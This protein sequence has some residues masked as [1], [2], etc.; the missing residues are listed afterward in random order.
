MAKPHRAPRA[1][2]SY[3]HDSEAHKSWVLI[4]C[5]RLVR[6]GVDVILDQWDVRLGADLPAFMERGL[7]EAD[8]VLAICTTSYVTK[9]NA[10][11]GGVGYEKMILTAQLM[12]DL[13]SARVFPV[14]KDNLAAHPLPTFLASRAYIDFRVESEYESKYSLLLHEIHGEPIQPRPP[15]GPNPFREPPPPM[16]APVLP[17]NADRYVNPALRGVV[18]FDPTNNDGKF[19]IGTGDMAFE[20]CW[21]SLNP[22]AIFAYHDPPSIRT[23][24]IAN[25]ARAIE[26]IADAA[27]YDG[28]SRTRAPRLGEIVIWQN[29]AGYFAATQITKLVLRSSINAENIFG[30]RYV[31]QPNRSGSFL[32]Q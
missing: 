1:F 8:R 18:E 14:V 12:Q 5:D 15:L 27:R 29:T 7:T 4:L 19:I 13:T 2:C 10:G 9:A 31:I 23:V 25:D 20:T 26:E 11:R 3:S 21:G 30:F 22:D 24:A 32:T 16:R 6:N 17:A 28:S